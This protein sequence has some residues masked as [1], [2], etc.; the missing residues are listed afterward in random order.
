M[1]ATSQIEASPPSWS[2]SYYDGRTAS[3]Q[4][5]TVILSAQGLI[6]KNKD[7][8]RLY[9]SYEDIRLAPMLSLSDPVRLECG[10]PLPQSIVIDDPSFLSALRPYVHHRYRHFHLPAPTPRR[11]GLLSM[12]LIASLVTIGV[13][14]RWGIP[15]LAE[16]A[17][18]LVPTSWEVALGKTVL[19][20]LVTEDERCTNEVLRKETSLLLAQLVD[21]STSPYE[22][23]LTIVDINEFNAYTLPGGEIVIFRP[24]LQATKTPDELAGVL[25]HEIQHVVLRHSIKSI[26]SDLSLATLIGAVLGNVTGLGAL[27]TE[28]AGAL[29]TLHYSRDMEEQADAEGI[30][31][32][33]KANF[34]PTGMIRFF[35]TV[36]RR[37]KHLNIP[38]YLSTHPQTEN[39]IARLKALLNDMPDIPA[40]E[41]NE[42]WKQTTTL[43]HG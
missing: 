16:R 38:P 35:E 12:A 2:A 3:R 19:E 27:S 7:A 36:Q 18:P 31:L 28:I 43:C 1:S 15:A 4:S 39:R 33:Q 10:T 8:P 11:I 32:L 37:E 9:W 40:L 6:I 26:L 22:L 29:S 23:H 25:A 20:Q 21:P 41:Q 17:T 30:R 24:L 13:I 34:N 42:G 5:V 14:I